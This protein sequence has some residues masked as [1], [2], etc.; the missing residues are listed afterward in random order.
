MK[1]KTFIGIALP[2]ALGACGDLKDNNGVKAAAL[3]SPPTITFHINQ[4][5]SEI[6][7][8]QSNAQKVLQGEVRLYAHGGATNHSEICT[9]HFLDKNEYQAG[10]IVFRNQT[11]SLLPDVEAKGEVYA[12]ARGTQWRTFDQRE[13]YDLPRGEY[14]LCVYAKNG[15]VAYASPLTV[16]KSGEN[17]KAN[18]NT[19]GISALY[20]GG[21]NTEK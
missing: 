3:N 8:P 16:S 19:S 18:M 11:I 6:L 7:Q 17:F 5:T 21:F 4:K 14:L 2:F 15:S 12:F 13:L 9:A 1:M 20:L 10:N